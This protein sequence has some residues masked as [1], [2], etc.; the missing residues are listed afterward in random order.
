MV[1][2]PVFDR[3]YFAPETYMGPADERSVVFTLATMIAEWASRYP[4]QIAYGIYGQLEDHH[5]L[6]F[7][8]PLAGVL[9]RALRQ[10]PG[11]RPSLTA[12]LA[13]LAACPR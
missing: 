9:S 3:F 4:F 11:D 10:S 8:E 7:P 13:E 1:T 12:F 5:P 6:E 2:H